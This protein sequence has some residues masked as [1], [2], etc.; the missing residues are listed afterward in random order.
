MEP[1][2]LDA[3]DKQLLMLLQT[4]AKMRTKELAEAVGL[5][6]TPTYERVKRLEREGYIRAYV[7][8]LNREKIGRR[9][10]VLCQVSLE[11][12][13]KKL[14]HEFSQAIQCFSEVLVCY[15]IAGNYDFMLKIAVEDMRS[16]QDFTVNKLAT[17]DNVATVHS[18]F[19]LDELKNETV[20]ELGEE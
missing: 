13:S 12:H 16:Y 4:D 14:L 3:I 6:L 8:L 1:V 20:F 17:L 11:R 5:S 15:H 2:D 10:M 9:L 18:A 19:V 7:A